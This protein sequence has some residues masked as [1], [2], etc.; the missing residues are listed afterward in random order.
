VHSPQREAA[1]QLE[2]WL[3]SQ[4]SER[5]LGSGGYVWP[6]IGSL[7][8]LFAASW[9]GKGVDPTSFQTEATWN[10]VYWPVTPGMNQ[11]QLDI[12][13]QLAPAYLNG[14]NVA[15]AVDAAARQANGDLATAG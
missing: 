11:A 3:G 7:D 2:Q 13:N 1:W 6:G 4:A 10:V 5:V 9:K 14:G 15:Q 12:A 8:S